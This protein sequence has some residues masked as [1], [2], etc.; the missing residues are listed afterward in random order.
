[1]RAVLL[2][3]WT[4][5]VSVF[6]MTRGGMSGTL[7]PLAEELRIVNE[8][9]AASCWGRNEDQMTNKRGSVGVQTKLFVVRR[10]KLS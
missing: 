4:C 9:V 1:M 5:A 10:W 3:E 7:A 2:A 8:V 6:A